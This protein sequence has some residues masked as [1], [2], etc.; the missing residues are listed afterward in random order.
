MNQNES[1]KQTE[2]VTPAVNRVL[3]EPWQRHSL[4][5]L[6]KPAK[7]LYQEICKI[8]KDT[9]KKK[10]KTNF[11]QCFYENYY[12]LSKVVVGLMRCENTIIWFTEKGLPSLGNALVCLAEENKLCDKNIEVLIEEI[13]PHREITSSDVDT[14][15][16]QYSYCLLKACV[17][18]FKKEDDSFFMLVYK[19]HTASDINFFS[20][21]DKTNPLELKFK[22]D[23]IYSNMTAESRALYRRKV[24]QISQA[25][26]VKEERLSWQYLTFAKEKDN[27]IGFQIEQDYRRVFP[28]PNPKSYFKWI[29]IL[30][31]SLS[32]ILG[33]LLS[34]QFTL[35]MFFPVYAVLKQIA[36]KIVTHKVKSISGHSLPRL[37]F[38][39]SIP[40]YAK[41]L[42]VVSTLLGNEDSIYEAIEKVTEIQSRNPSEN[43]YFCL[44]CDLPQAKTGT[45]ENDEK[46]IVSCKK[47][48]ENNYENNKKISVIIRNRS[49]CETQSS[50]SGWE[51]KR[52]A[53][54]QLI[55]H[56]RGDFQE[57][58][59]VLGGDNFKDIRYMLAL[60]YDTMPL[61]DTISE[62]VSIAVL[63]TNIPVI[64]NG[65]VVSGYGIIAPKMTTSL[66]SS[67]KTM[68]SKLMGG[69]GGN[70]TGTYERLSADLYMDGFEEGIFAGKGLID[71]DAFY[72]LCCGKFKD[73]RILSH[74]IIEG[75][76][77]RVGFSDIE[78]IDSFPSTTKAYFKRQDRWYR[79]DLQNLPFLFRHIPYKENGKFRTKTPFSPLSRIKLWDNIRRIVTPPMVLACLYSHN[80]WIELIG[81]LG[82]LFPFLASFFVSIFR[83]GKF[84]LVRRFYSSTLS[85]ARQLLYQC[86]LEIILLP[87]NAVVS[88][89]AI[90]KVLW[91][92]LFTKKNLLEWTTAEQMGKN[93]STTMQTVKGF[94]IAELISLPL[95]FGSVLSICTG[96]LCL[97]ALPVMLACDRFCSVKKVKITPEI[98]QG[99]QDS[100]E[101]ML[102]FYE[103]Y[104][105]KSDNYLPPDNVQYSPVY[106]VAHRTS[107]T[108][109]GMY[110][111]SLVCGR[112]FGIYNDNQ[113]R[114]RINL[115]LTTVEKLEKWQGNLY[116]WYD[117][118]KLSKLESFVSTVDSG[119]FVCCMV[120]VKEGLL[121]LG[122]KDLSSRI[123]KIIDETNLKPFYN[124]VKKLF[125]IGVN[126]DTLE[127][128]KNHY[129]L[130]MSEARMTS[131]F[132]IG[133]GIVSKDH[134]QSLG[135]LMSKSGF[136]AGAVSWTGTM[137]E[138]FMPE[139]LLKS[140]EGSFAH[141]SLKFALHYQRKQN[142]PFGFSESAYF[143]FDDMLNY[144]YKAHGIQKL[145]L[146]QGLNNDCVVSP[147]SS[148]LTLGYDLYHSW[149]NLVLL[150]EMGVY[151]K[152]YGFYEAIDMTT[153]R[154]GNIEKHYE[155]VKSHMAHHVGMSILAATNAVLEGAVQELFLRDTHMRRAKELLEE[156][157]IGGSILY[158]D[159][160]GK[161]EY[162]KEASRISS[163][164][165]EEI[166]KFTPESP[167]VSIL[168]NNTVTGIYSDNGYSQ[169]I[170]KGGLSFFPQNNPLEP[171]RGFSA[172]FKENSGE[173]AFV[174]PLGMRAEMYFPKNCDEYEQNVLFTDKSA[175]YYTNYRNLNTGMKCGLLTDYPC[176]IREFAAKNNASTTRL[177]KLC[178]FIEP[179]LAG[180]NDVQAHPAFMDLFL[181]CRFNNEKQIFIVS[182]KER[183]GNNVK[184]MGIAFSEKTM[185]NFSMNKEN[186]INRM[187]ENPYCSF[188]NKELSEN[189]TQSVPVPCVYIQADFT[190]KPKEQKEK[191][192]IILYGDSE[193][194]IIKGIDTIRHKISRSEEK[195][196]VFLKSTVQ[197]RIVTELLPHIVFNLPTQ[198]L[199]LNARNKNRYNFKELWKW[200]ISGDLP[201]IMVDSDSGHSEDF[202]WGLLQAQHMLRLN[203]L[204]FD[205]IFLSKTNSDFDTNIK[206]IIDKLALSSFINVR[207]GIFM[208][209]KNYISS[210]EYEL[211]LSAS[212][213]NVDRSLTSQGSDGY[214]PL[215]ISNSKSPEKNQMKYGYF[216]GKY[217]VISKAPPNPWC[218]IL[219]NQSFGTMVSDSSLGFSWAINSREMKISPW[220]NNLVQDNYGER[221]FL[222]GKDKLYDLIKGSSCAF[223]P[224]EA[225]YKSKSRGILFTVKV[226]IS[227]NS[228]GKFIEVTMA[229]PTDKV[230]EIE[231]AYYVDFILGV[232]NS[233]GQRLKFTREKNYLA[234]ENAANISI[235]GSGIM[236]AQIY[237]DDEY[238]DIGFDVCCNKLRL[239]SGKWQENTVNSPYPCGSVIVKRELPPRGKE[240]IR[241][242]LGFTENCE[243]PATAL[244]AIKTPVIKSETLLNRDNKIIINTPDKEMDSLFNSW[245]LWQTLGGRI[246]GRTG[247]YQNGG[248]FGFRDQLQDG[249]SMV[250]QKPDVTKRLILRACGAQFKEGD[251]LHWWHDLPSEM[252]G[253]RTRYSDDLL[254]L[255]FVT[256]FYVKTTG[257]RDILSI[258]VCYAVGEL[259]EENQHEKYMTVTKGEKAT[260]YQHCKASIEKAYKL[261]E[262]ELLLMG[263][264]DWNDGYNNVG[265]QGKGES[266]WL[267]MFMIMVMEQFIP[268]SRHFGDKDYPIT[269]QFRAD[270]LKKAIDNSCYENGYYTR[271]FYDNGEKMGS[272]ENEQCR[273]DL[274]PQ[275]FSVLSGVGD[276]SRRISAINNA[277]SQLVDYNGKLIKLFTPA[278]D[279]E[280]LSQDPGYVKSY[281]VGVRE[282]G[283]QYT[284]AAVWLCMAVLELGFCDEAYELIRILNPAL[285]KTEVFRNEP[286]FM[287]AD[288]YTN[289]SAYGRGGWS[290]YTGAAGWYYQCILK[291]LGI[292][293]AE[294]YLTIK[295]LVAKDWKG[296]SAE[297]TF[298]NTMISLLV[299]RG[300]DKGIWDN[301]IKCDKVPLDGAEHIVKVII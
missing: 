87:K 155:I 251:V 239:L 38:K 295:P 122:M 12:V 46:I 226:K 268:L 172:G 20:I 34:W 41:T 253:T 13:K 93:L 15:A 283:G 28:L 297:I 189:E 168:S 117:T 39:G 198:E 301:Q 203:G 276:S 113:L 237:K 91:R 236:S 166:E 137:F 86:L 216:N 101:A 195:T 129:D 110:M 24:S 264:G 225:L 90:C 224:G 247:Y 94:V 212:V 177:L 267:S 3:S 209:D 298:N 275:A 278:F 220:S 196:A 248:A 76:L 217:Y 185:L 191:K 56:L 78:F 48:L 230:K 182:R 63:P 273:I 240:K 160:S 233:K 5:N 11:E 151:H 186:V 128:S 66:E 261:G 259:L 190:L 2:G 232:D 238:K 265:I 134:W 250:Y 287:S 192:L 194:E 157:I 23:K 133:K 156:R 96:V 284:H 68:F 84:A 254:W 293:F 213:Y 138:Y 109:I 221:I 25:A 88:T 37:D 193:E 200:G 274:L 149:N 16:A 222:K 143:A 269:L 207:G 19:I 180:K 67:Q 202:L 21:T 70:S 144:Q 107:P 214:K 289:P 44:L 176:E 257:D 98:R 152:D 282:N 7:R 132:A 244:S 71:V 290:I 281:P 136:Y 62:L 223:A 42:A 173:N 119:N 33:V 148:F 292:E 74:D 163:S 277:L 54:E 8:Y 116:N 271:A 27:F 150:R 231:L 14:L 108:N 18:R 126:A 57:F 51:R 162:G 183:H 61:M 31:L 82:L 243:N 106:A 153:E 32:I 205:L 167:K 219:A 29:L 158:Q 26:G 199:I 112:L 184:Y 124:P 50:W 127:F 64:E 206:L 4:I 235:N 81:L 279:N 245:L 92:G 161:D 53:I 75:S 118:E 95:L 272:A 300:D 218:N 179:A 89:A 10:L 159:I 141:E 178:I 59:A 125:S 270:S 249:M 58:Q 72:K 286:Y 103:N 111:L 79:G 139:L 9:E 229:N 280:N 83:G 188:Y 65:R 260:V 30:S 241:F 170:Y 52:G 291:L 140:Q 242:I 197:G 17:E 22:D 1:L 100:I 266:V 208:L 115:T 97:S 6:N 102:N 114:H 146:K 104:V 69:L 99:I 210:D 164:Q 255:P 123:D 285:K 171:M 105:V 121:Q 234:V 246:Y 77:L 256:A 227:K 288:I 201:V 35:L 43:L 73:Q 211:L 36:D 85:Q 228:M 47:A 174:I 131:Y 294:G 60:D 215:K 181:K 80:I 49:Y 120:A 258:P 142:T 165:K 147:Y 130:L 145:G 135:R 187:E 169:G 262:H 55:M 40:D 175:E 296:Y 204:Q 45:T 263:C 299:A 154:T 252:K